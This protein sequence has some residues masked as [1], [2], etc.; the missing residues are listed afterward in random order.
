MKMVLSMHQFSIFLCSQSPLAQSCT[1]Y[2]WQCYN[3]KCIPSS[4]RCDGDNDCGD[5]SDE[6]DC[7]KF[8]Y[9]AIGLSGPCA[10]PCLYKKGYI[11]LLSRCHSSYGLGI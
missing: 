1:G 6:T 2:Q 7:C 4:Y 8:Q 10:D 5:N 3:D 11:E 9:S